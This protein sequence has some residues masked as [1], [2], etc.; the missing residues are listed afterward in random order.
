[1][2]HLRLVQVKLLKFL[3][4]TEFR[5]MHWSLTALED[6]AGGETEEQSFSGSQ[7]FELLGKDKEISRCVED[8]GV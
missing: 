4:W 8:V 7:R 5:E 2:Q 3:R 6:M 1:M